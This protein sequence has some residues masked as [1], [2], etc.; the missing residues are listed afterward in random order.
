MKA[1]QGKCQVR[2][3]TGTEKGDRISDTD[4][5]RRFSKE[6]AFEQDF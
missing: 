3:A 1:E 2:F 6:V 5:L 4:K